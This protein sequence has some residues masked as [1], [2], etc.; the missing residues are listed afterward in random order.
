MDATN[1]AGRMI[2]GVMAEVA[3]FEAQRIIE[4]TKEAMAAAKARGVKLGG[5][6]EEAI[7]ANKPRSANAV[8]RAE[9]LRV[10]I[11]A[12]VEQV[13]SLKSMTEALNSAEHKTE[14]NSD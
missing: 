4:R 10:V 1:A 8:R 3:Q 9:A 11:T 12:M 5:R 13:M 2:L 14:R 7:Q 6:R